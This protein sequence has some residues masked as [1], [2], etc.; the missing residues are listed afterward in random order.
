ML[1]DTVDY[2]AKS[3]H[4]FL[5]SKALNNTSSTAE[6]NSNIHMFKVKRVQVL[7]WIKNF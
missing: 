4:V 3:T 2:V 5:R 6:N 1:L 7:C